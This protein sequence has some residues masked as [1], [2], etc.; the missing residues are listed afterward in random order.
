M[1]RRTRK[2]NQKKVTENRKGATRHKTSNPPVEASVSDP[3][4]R[5]SSSENGQK[6]E[7]G[8]AKPDEIK[9]QKAVKYIWPASLQGRR[10]IIRIAIAVLL[11]IALAGLAQIL[12]GPFAMTIVIAVFGWIVSYIANNIER[13]LGTEYKLTLPWT[14]QSWLGIAFLS[15]ILFQSIPL[16][17]HLWLL[18]WR[19]AYGDGFYNH[20]IVLIGTMFF[21]WAGFILCGVLIAYLMPKR[22]LTATLVG[23]SFF[24]GIMA[25]E[26]FTGSFNYGDFTIIASLLHSDADPQGFNAFR[27]GAVVGLISRVLLTV[28]VARLISRRRLR[29]RLSR[30]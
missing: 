5:G 6:P 7:N 25:A 3:I 4:G 23:A 22:H 20:T 2:N 28:I 27:A 30:A 18:P 29:R 21:D 24:I 10:F 19:I 8:P 17:L 12:L 15:I 26:A 14:P 16:L 13:D 11:L 9:E 1:S